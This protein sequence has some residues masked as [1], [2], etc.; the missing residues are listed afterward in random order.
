MVIRT[1]DDTDIRSLE[2]CRVEVEAKRAFVRRRLT[3]PERE[4]IDQFAFNEIDY[5]QNIRPVETKYENIYKEY[6][7]GGSED[8]D[9]DVMDAYQSSSGDPTTSIDAEEDDANSE[10]STALVSILYVILLFQ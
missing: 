3:G 1:A 9:D 6:F 2:R 10:N 7:G 5:E 4:V 8:E